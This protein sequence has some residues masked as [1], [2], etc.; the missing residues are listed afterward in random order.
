MNRFSITARS[1]RTSRS[2]LSRL[3]VLLLALAGLASL[4]APAQAAGPTFV[5]L[6][7]DNAP[8][9]HYNLGYQQA[10]QPHNAPATFFVS[11]GAVGSSPAQMT[12]AQLGALAAA[13]NDIG[14]RSVNATNLTTD[15]NPQAQVCNDR[16]A[17]IAHG[18]TPAGFAYPGGANNATVQNVVKSCGYGTARGIVSG[19]AAQAV[20]R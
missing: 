12:W 15:P 1:R 10:L 2:R 16:A 7:F 9:S 3:V 11:S 5:T 6:E 17:I 18:L 20:I 4:A 8:V 13:G 14:G 19:P